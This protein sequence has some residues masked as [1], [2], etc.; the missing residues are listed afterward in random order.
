MLRW[1]RRIVLLL[2]AG[3]VLYF[4]ATFFRVWWTA[5]RDEARP[6]QAIVVLGAAQYDGR[7][8]PVLKARL[9]HVLELWNRKLAPVVV[10]TGGRAAGDRFTEATA[11]A[12]YLSAHGIPDSAI[13]RETSGRNS[14]DSLAASARFLGTRGIHRVLLVSDPFHAA[15]IAAIASEVGLQGYTS[16]TRTSPIRGTSAL[17]RMAQETVV[18]GTGQIFGFRRLVRIERVRRP[19]AAILTSASARLFQASRSG[20]V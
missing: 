17:K 15:R 4:G 18:V 16:P 20:V 2:V 11:S 3:G 9:D 10:V 5:R 19:V 12:T 14:W 6:A 13:L 7:P 1:I 8:S